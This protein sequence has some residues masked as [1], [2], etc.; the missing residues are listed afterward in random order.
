MAEEEAERRTATT[1]GKEVL[2]V[3][4]AGAVGGKGALAEEME[5][6]EE[7]VVPVLYS[8]WW[9]FH[10]GRFGLRRGAGAAVRLQV[11]CTSYM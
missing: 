11:P 5:E 4:P 7:R 10:S 2:L 3:G 9:W 6:G 1:L 8:L